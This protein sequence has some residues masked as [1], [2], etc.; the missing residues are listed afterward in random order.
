MNLLG[1]ERSST[2]MPLLTVQGRKG[3]NPLGRRCPFC[4]EVWQR[5]R[6][7]GKLCFLVYANRRSEGA[8]LSMY[9][10]WLYQ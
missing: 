2:G 8:V 9:A 3:T 6:G 10:P 4:G 5:Y 1:A 7:R